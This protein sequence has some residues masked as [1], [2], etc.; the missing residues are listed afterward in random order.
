MYKESTKD[1]PGIK[2][3]AKGGWDVVL[4]SGKVYKTYVSMA[5]AKKGLAQADL[6]EDKAEASGKMFS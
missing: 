2:K 6:E 4:S 3:N 1:E 5:E